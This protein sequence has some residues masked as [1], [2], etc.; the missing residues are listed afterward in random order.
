MERSPYRGLVPYR[1]EDEPF[2]FGREREREIIAA[3]LL[4]ARLTLLYGTSGVGK[5][6]VLQAGAVPF[7]RR[8]TRQGWLD[9][10]V[11][12]SFVAV[13][14]RW[15]DDPVTGIR[16]AVEEAIRREGTSVPAGSDAEAPLSRY[17]RART[18]QLQCDLLL[19]LDQFEEYFLYHGREEGAG[20]FAEEFPT[21]V[22]REGLRVNV[23]VSIREDALARLDRFKGRIPNLFRNFL[24]ID[25]LDRTAAERAIAGPIEQYN[26]LF[27]EQRKPL[28][29][30][31]ALVAAVIEQI[32][33]DRAVLGSLTAGAPL[34]Q[35]AAGG[36]RVQ[37]PY[38][39]LVMSR[40][41]EEERQ[42]G[43]ECLRAETLR[44]LG[45]AEQIIRSH[46]E[47][48]V[49]TLSGSERDAAVRVF[50]HLVT[51]SGTKIAHTAA[52]LAAYTEE[53]EKRVS[54]VLET[55]A[56]PDV[57]IVRP[58]DSPTGAAEAPRYEITHDV[59]G[60]AILEW[61]RRYLT[62][63]A[64]EREALRVRRRQRRLLLAVAAVL[65]LI[66]VAATVYLWRQWQTT[67]HAKIAADKRIATVEETQRVLDIEQ[68]R[69]DEERRLVDN[70]RQLVAHLEQ[71][72]SAFA[73]GQ[74]AVARGH[75][76][77]A[78]PLS[79][80]AAQLDPDGLK[81]RFDRYDALA[82]L[83]DVA[84]AERRLPDARTAYQAALT[85]ATQLAGQAPDSD[86]VQR[87]LALAQRR[88]GDLAATDGDPA[89]A[90]RQ[91]REALRTFGRILSLRPGLENVRAERA[92]TL[93]RLADADRAAGDPAAAEMH[94]S[95]AEAAMATSP[96]APWQRR[97]AETYEPL[98]DEQFG[99]KEWDSAIA[100]Y[101]R[102]LAALTTAR[103]AETQ[104][105]EWRAFV[106]RL[107][108]KQGDTALRNG[109]LET[110][111]AAYERAAALYAAL[112]G[113]PSAD[114]LLQRAYRGVLERRAQVARRRGDLAGVQ[115]WLGEAERV[116]SAAARLA[117]EN[118][119]LQRERLDALKSLGEAA[120]VRGEVETAQR[121]YEGALNLTL[122][123]RR[124][125]R[126]G[127]PRDWAQA[128]LATRQRMAD[129]AL[130]RGE[131][132]VA[133][134]ELNA[135]W[136]G[137]VAPTG[138]D[139]A[140][141]LELGQRFRQLGQTARRAG[142]LDVAR[143]AFEAVIELGTA[144]DGAEPID[145]EWQRYR[146]IDWGSLADVAWAQGNVKRARQAYR[147][148]AEAF[149][150]GSSKSQWLIV[151]ASDPDVR[152][153]QGTLARVRPLGLPLGVYLRD[154]HY[155]T[156]AGPYGPNEDVR[157][158]LKRVQRQL[159]PES[160]AVV[161]EQWCPL[162]E[163]LREGELALVRCKPGPA[164]PRAASRKRPSSLQIPLQEGLYEY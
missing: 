52:D 44:R 108:A 111:D 128:E 110:A 153:A 150:P 146:A 9:P 118:E 155:R 28:Q 71:A 54:H 154:G 91:Y 75:Y 129:V 11:P 33:S 48:A 12:E 20:S 133:V 94:Y 127:A 126:P 73:A 144:A 142:R 27:R 59:L 64:Q 145:K 49:A 89:E 138:E 67:L 113:Q 163:P 137:L 95:E 38:L 93:R 69:L 51:P 131:L 39:Q 65:T 37:T 147:Q 119:A 79:E 77:A 109:D 30:E 5:S 156:A 161:L 22:N 17:L 123:Q 42:R 82:G 36:L 125:E 43:S 149:V 40:I 112:G 134:R 152:A 25:A 6:S 60:P 23:V 87:A 97:M 84:L 16:L 103:G 88:L 41:W 4:A 81:W 53:P 162:R 21:I 70:S 72:G 157:A 18:E 56:R 135:S 105:P 26:R 50:H 151:I 58:V 47:M 86:A 98:G 114:V 35:D 57:R 104:S 63:Q 14:S 78:L 1:E 139:A 66:G 10:D 115:Q 15:R 32:R 102:A 80:K 132:D 31:P 62:E 100:W 116:A 19:I 121:A 117:P 74:Y 2:F 120:L 92:E 130:Q 61:R 76:E 55:F 24:R 124:L 101:R 160:L 143:Q 83:G 107:E 136:R 141:A 8:T 140:L 85:V 106:A 122:E 34:P 164:S 13:Y 99:K 159:Q 68:A 29:L 90:R 45:G 96:S 148:A 7:L 158:D 46:L 3:N